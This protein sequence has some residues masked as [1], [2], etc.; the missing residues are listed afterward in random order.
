MGD[1]A[2]RLDGL[3]T[4]VIGASRGIGA[5]I[6]RAYAAEGAHVACAARRLDSVEPLASELAGDGVRTTAVAIDLQDRESITQGIDETIARFGGIDVLVQNG[7]VSLTTPFVDVTYEQW[8]DV[9]ATNLDGT[10]VACQHVARHLLDR[11]EPGSMI[12]VTSQL[13]QVAIPNKAPYLA[14]KGG[15]TM[16]T[17]SMALELAPH[18]IRVNALAPGVTRTDMA[19]SRLDH[20]PEALA[21]TTERIPMGRLGEADEMAGAAVFL[22]SEEASY[23]TGSTLLVDGG[24]LTK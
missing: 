3:R 8:R 4:L 12:V 21:W 7:G 15:L 20:D 17:K 9:L 24:Y 16:L 19:M 23:V 14:S 18:G 5:E 11:Q 22:A 13:S 10:F 2:A 6:A 1:R